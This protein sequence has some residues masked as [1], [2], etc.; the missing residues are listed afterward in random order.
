[1]EA[2]IS[3]SCESQDP[4]TPGRGQVTRLSASLRGA[5]WR[6]HRECVSASEAG[7]SGSDRCHGSDRRP[8]QTNAQSVMRAEHVGRECLAGEAYRRDR[9]RE[10][11]PLGSTTRPRDGGRH[12]SGRGQPGKVHQMSVAWR[13]RSHRSSRF[14]SRRQTYA[15]L[16]RN[17]SSA[18]AMASGV[19]TCI[20]T[21]SR[22]RPN[23]RSCSFARS[24]IWVSEN[25]PFGASAKIAGEMMAAPA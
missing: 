23:R 16:S 22:R 19:P 25:A 14:A 17:A 20:Q 21:P 4:I 24:N 7:W 11:G 3:S 5:K 1:M 12:G 18:A 6:P 15:T 10:R 13:V 2:T 8:D 9:C